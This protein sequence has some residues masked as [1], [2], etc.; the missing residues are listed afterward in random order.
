M[1]REIALQILEKENLSVDFL[2]DTNGWILDSG[3]NYIVEAVTKDSEGRFRPIGELKLLM[4]LMARAP[5]MY[6]LLKCCMEKPGN[7]DSSELVEEI[8]KVLKIV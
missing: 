7:Y 3:G 5:K 6:R 2:D 1:K 4:D 8:E